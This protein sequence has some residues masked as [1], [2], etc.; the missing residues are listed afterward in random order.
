MSVFE[1]ISQKLARVSGWK[2][3][4]QSLAAINQRRAAMARWSDDD[5]HTAAARSD[6]SLI[7]SF[8]ASATV[9]ERV[10]GQRPFDVQILGALAMADGKIAEM[11]T[12]EGK[13]L[14][15]TLTVFHLAKSH[16]GCHV[17]TANDYLARRDAEWMG[18]I[19]RF[20]GLSV[21]CVAQGMDPETR[22][23]AYACDIT[24]ATANEVGFDYLRDGSALRTQDLVQR[25][26]D[27]ALIDEA[28]SILIDEARIPLVI[29]GGDAPPHEMA[30]RMAEI[31][32]RLERWRD[33][34]LD[35]HARNVS[36]TD[37]GIRKA[38]L[39][40]GCSN[41]Y[42]PANGELLTALQNAL[43]AEI[44]L[45]RDVDYLV[46]HGRI[47][48]VDE[49]KGRIAENRRWPAELQTA[50][51]AKEGIALQKQGRVLGS[52][53]L[54]NLVSLYTNVCGMTGTAATQAKEFKELYDLD[55]VV[56]PTHRPGIREDHID[57]IFETK[58]EKEA[59][60]LEEIANVHA[61]GRPVLVGTASVAE[62]E[63]LSAQLSRTAIAHEVLNARND[64]RESQ[65]VARAGE[66]GAVTISTNM[67][68]RGTD[69]PLGGEQVRARGG[70]HVIG[71]N[72]HES[73]RID[74][75]LRGRAARQGDPGSSRFFISTEDDLLVRYGVAQYLSYE[76]VA[77]A[78]ES[79]QS[80]I[81]DE[82]LQIRQ[83]L[84]KYE[85][86]LE[87]HRRIARAKRD[88]MLEQGASAAELIRL[89]DLWADHL[90]RTNELREG[91]VWISLA[92]KNPY[93]EFLRD[94]SELFDRVIE[95]FDNPD[96]HEH[97]A[98]GQDSRGATWT[99]LVND[100]PF[101]SMTDRVV[102]GL[103]SR[104]R[105]RLE[106]R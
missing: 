11:Q 52:I 32:R 102:A 54:Q 57:E 50:L 39:A 17:L 89:D 73:R 96:A 92:G 33:Y 38:E 29:A 40:S 19:Y 94:T 105:D 101:G 84:W 99:Y 28:D 49:F 46:K 98:N 91:V 72:R 41:F 37:S 81:E 51:E 106:K 1:S 47:E 12:G 43:H 45:H 7:E 20:L 77:E 21:A 76:H 10:L 100:Q 74:H 59:A 93:L 35:P 104:I 65:I 55:V 15:A 16:R 103:R 83:M 13:T 14:A 22:R 26:F 78:I 88:E 64:E 2:Q 27:T 95:S 4:Q 82:N 56:I 30:R 31:V 3:H 70:L 75:Q 24:Y 67:A 5:L 60:V 85:I 63:R 87:Q 79:V 90:A 80:I 34:T 66:L 86:L 44:L 6:D 69:I 53:T 97:V 36:L 23:R 68:G 61:T 48:L 42:D 71:T 18:G 9:A 58:S 25:P 62:S 8:A